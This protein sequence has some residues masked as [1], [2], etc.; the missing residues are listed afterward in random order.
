MTKSMIKTKQTTNRN[1]V[2]TTAIKAGEGRGHGDTGRGGHGTTKMEEWGLRDI[3]WTAP[4]FDSF[5]ETRLPG[6]TY[7]TD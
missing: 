5:S 6:T 3:W 2:T 4:S 7:K 1:N